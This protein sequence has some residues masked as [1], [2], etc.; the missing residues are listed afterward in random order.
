MCLLG[1][2]MG[3]GAGGRVGGLHAV[4]LH[5]LFVFGVKH[6]HTTDTGEMASTDPS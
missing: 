1:W 6:K 2:P 3:L 4:P 5:S